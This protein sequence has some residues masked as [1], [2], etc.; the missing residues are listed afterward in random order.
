MRVRV[1]IFVQCLLR[2]TILIAT[3]SPVSLAV[4]IHTVPNAP[5]FGF[6]IGIGFGIG[7]GFGLKLG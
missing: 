4:A 3:R 5:G 2:S 6:G 1:E 7:F